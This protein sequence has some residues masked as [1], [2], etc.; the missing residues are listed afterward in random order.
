MLHEV[1]N[2]HAFPVAVDAG[3][4]LCADGGNRKLVA[5]PFRRAFRMFLLVAAV[6]RP[7]LPSTDVQ[8]AVG[9]IRAAL[10][11]ELPIVELNDLAAVAGQ[12]A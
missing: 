2:D 10:D 5:A 11:G 7:V 8:V 9:G 3:V 1:R 4:D 12:V 6:L